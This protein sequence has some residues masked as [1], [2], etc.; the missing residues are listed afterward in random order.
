M[1]GVLRYVDRAARA[2]D[3]T[4]GDAGPDG[5]GLDGDPGYGG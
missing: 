2:E 4:D 3:G 5:D 1:W